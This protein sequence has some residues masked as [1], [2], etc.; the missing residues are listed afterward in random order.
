MSKPTADRSDTGDMPEVALRVISNLYETVADGAPYEPMFFAMDAVIEQLFTDP[1]DGKTTSRWSPMFAPH[2]HRAAHVFDIMSRKETAT[3]LSFVDQRHAP[4]AVVDPECRIIATNMG[5]DAIMTEPWADGLSPLF[6]TPADRTRF[7]ALAKANRPDAQAILN[8]VL[9]GKDQPQSFL[10]GQAS[11]LEHENEAGAPLYLTL[12]Q[13]R[14]TEKTG[15]LLQQAFGLTG[16]EVDTMRLFLECGSIKG[17]ASRRRRSIR[18]VRTQLSRVFAQMGISGQTELALFLATLSG[19]EPLSDTLANGPVAKGPRSDRLVAHKFT[20]AGHA[21]EVYDY[22]APNGHPVLLL[23]SSHPP[24]LTADL[25]RALFREGLRIIAPLKPGSGNSVS[26]PGMPGPEEMT[27][28]YEELLDRLKLDKVIVAGQASGGLYA[29]NFTKA[30]PARIHAVAL[31]DTGVPFA[32]RAEMM[33]LHTSIRRTLVPA[34]YF[35]E[36]LYLP[37][38]LVAA[39]FQ[40][41]A[42]GE[43]SVVDYF[44]NGSPHDQALTRTDRWAYDVTRRIISYSFDDTTRLVQDVTRWANDWTPALSA[45]AAGHRLRFI[46]G[47]QNT[48]FKADK[49]TRFVEPYPNVDHRILAGGQLAVFEQPETFSTALG[50]LGTSM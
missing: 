4:T 41:S 48:M 38:K 47:A 42:R 18:T 23:Q 43:E 33:Q 2:F 40:R 22:G 35:P 34:R 37:H 7:A 44:F 45:V 39:N 46:H 17:V 19:M 50:E 21:V 15:K 1:H 25:R 28:L 30:Y 36:L 13:P 6:A 27:Q 49:I 20:L 10:A 12:I 31:I 32:D 14:W 8:L 3:P 24:E 11:Q 16:A 26:I 5:F 9:P 29:L